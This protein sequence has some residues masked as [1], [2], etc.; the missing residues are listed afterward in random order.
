MITA[1]L[2]N[3]KSNMPMYTMQALKNPLDRSHMRVKLTVGRVKFVKY[4]TDRAS[5]VFQVEKYKFSSKTPATSIQ[6]A[7]N[8]S[9]EQ[10]IG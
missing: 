5:A 6:I 8:F 7:N 9:N 3:M 10:K 4:S 1:L 2:T